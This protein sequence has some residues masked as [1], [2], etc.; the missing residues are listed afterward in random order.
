[1]VA[2]KTARIEDAVEV[3]EVVAMG[4]RG[5]DDAEVRGSQEGS[6][7]AQTTIRMHTNQRI[8]A[9][10]CKQCLGLLREARQ[11]PGTVTMRPRTMQNP[12]FALF[13]RI[14]SGT[15]RCRLA[16]TQRVTSAPSGCVPCTR[17]R[18]AHIVE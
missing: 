7:G 15:L 4:L 18:H 3:V 2:E 6:G 9:D 13:V 17:A 1:M 16:T 8:R 5:L 11:R 12:R 14:Q 10:P